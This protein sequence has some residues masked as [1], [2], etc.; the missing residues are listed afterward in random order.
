M[1]AL[2]VI[3]MVV[4]ALWFLVYLDRRTK[5]AARAC[6]SSC[7]LRRVPCISAGITRRTLP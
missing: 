6:L 3:V 5:R 2:N 1:A 4:C 7:L